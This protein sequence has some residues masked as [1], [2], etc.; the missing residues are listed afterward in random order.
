MKN[1][2]RNRDKDTDTDTGGPS[3]LGDGQGEKIRPRARDDPGGGFV[4]RIDD[5]LQAVLVSH[6]ILIDAVDGRTVRL[7]GVPIGAEFNKAGTNL[8]LH[9]EAGRPASVQAY[10]DAD[11]SYG[12]PDKKLRRAFRGDCRRDWRRLL[13]RIGHE[14][15]NY[16]LHEVLEYL[17][18]PIAEQVQRILPRASAE[19]SELGPA[20]RAV[21]HIVS[22]EAAAGAYARTFRKDLADQLS[23]TVTRPDSPS[24]V[25]LWAQSGAGR[26]LLMLSAAHRLIET[27][28][29][30]QVVR[31][32]GS[33]IAAGSIFPAEKDASLLRTLCEA[34]QRAGRV[35][36]IRDIDVAISGSS[37]SLS[38]LCDAIDMGMRFLAT[39]RSEQGLSQIAGDEALARRV[40]AVNLDEPTRRVVASVL[41]EIALTSPCK[42]TQAAINVILHLSETREA[43]GVEPARSVGLLNAAIHRAT[44]LGGQVDP[45]MIFAVQSSQWPE[46]I[47]EN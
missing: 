31:I 18:S 12:G 32:S 33:A 1:K 9:G 4:S 43:D 17:D 24:S 45:D 37:V 26:N 7:G 11:L 44:C 47:Q 10:V 6:N 30:E 40:V 39:V 14:D 3:G 23:V 46:V 13:I 29:A 36:L 19:S 41:Q 16:A 21:G 27:R 25:I 35:L 5:S 20:L 42:V 34:R 8:L 22:P 2:D 15:V 28:R 38:I